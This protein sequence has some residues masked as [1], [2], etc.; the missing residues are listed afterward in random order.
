[1]RRQGIGWAVT[2]PLAVGY[3]S[4]L[5]A[6]MLTPA[7][8]RLAWPLRG[9][10]ALPLCRTGSAAEWL[11]VTLLLAGVAF[12]YV[13]GDRALHAVHGLLQSMPSR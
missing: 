1:M 7:G 11:V 5:F 6:D 4:H 2:T 10:Y 13:Q 3:L 9:T 12:P 8:L